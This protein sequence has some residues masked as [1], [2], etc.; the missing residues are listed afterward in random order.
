MASSDTEIANL[1]LAHLGVAKEIANLE[2]ENS[3]E[4][5][6]I[7]RLWDTALDEMV[8]AFPWPF[9]TKIDTLTVVEEDPNEEWA[10]SYTYPTDCTAFRR[11][12][13]GA[14]TDT[15]QSKI[16]YRIISDGAGGRLILTDEEDAEGEWTLPASDDVTSWPSD[17]V[18]AFSLKLAFLGAPQL[19]AGDPFGLGRRAAQLYEIAMSRAA[20]TAANEE[21]PDEE[22]ES[23]FDR[24][25]D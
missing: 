4:A 3:Q 18:Q 12:L 24:A 11:I 7:R 21:Q 20:G 5:R 1:A 22:P 17:F 23:E 15:R 25:R 16:P 19:T 10:Y 8:R 6:T 14:R 13:S 9:L 2:T